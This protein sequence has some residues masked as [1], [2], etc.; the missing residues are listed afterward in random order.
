MAGLKAE[1]DSVQQREDPR[2][3]HT[4]N[5]RALSHGSRACSRINARCVAQDVVQALCLALLK[6]LLGQDA[7]FTR[8]GQRIPFGFGCADRHLFKAQ[9]DFL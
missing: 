2:A 6:I 3:R 7:D 9:L 1:P 5:V 4:S 8:R